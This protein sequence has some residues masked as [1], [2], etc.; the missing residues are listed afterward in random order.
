MIS[1]ENPVS[2]SPRASCTSAL[3]LTLSA[4]LL[5]LTLGLQAAHAD[6]PPK[7]KKALKPFSMKGEFGLIATTGNT[8]TMAFKGSLS[9][10][11]ELT[12]WSNDY[13]FEA[14][15][16]NETK[17]DDDGNEET[18]VS[19]EKYFGS[20]QA[21]YKLQNPD[22]RL[23]GFASYEKDRFSS[24]NYQSTLAIGWNQR[25]WEDDQSM[26]EY[27]I[28]PGYSFAETSDGESRDSPILRTSL[29][30]RYQFND[31]ASFEQSISTEFGSYNTKTKS[32]TA[33]VARITDPLA[34]KLS[35]TLD[36]NSKVDEGDDELDTQ[37]VVS[38]S[39]I[40][41]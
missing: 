24:Y 8:E 1:Q 28:G 27:S 20:G 26:F 7:I 11:Q 18:D 22:H 32:E 15:Y 2:H 19:A 36:H 25:L 39:Y 33:F 41:F 31:T 5:S 29:D 13:K 10:H 34:V 21:N 37:T 9:A 6:T 16:K 23:F 17:E 4:L 30:Y 40:F 12:D 38:L 14:L 3:T 35:L